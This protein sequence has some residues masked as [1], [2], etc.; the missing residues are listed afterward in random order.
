MTLLLFNP[1]ISIWKAFLV[2]TAFLY[3]ML[4]HTSSPELLVKL[5]H[6]APRAPRVLATVGSPGASG[7]IRLWSCTLA[8]F[9]ELE[10]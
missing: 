1:V 8:L 5:T 10:T 6:Q 3:R 2:P 7:G 9:I 4:R